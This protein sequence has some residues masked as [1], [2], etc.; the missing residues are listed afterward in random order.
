MLLQQTDFSR[1]KISLSNSVCCDC[2][3][4]Y[5]FVS[6]GRDLAVFVGHGQMQF[7]RERTEEGGSKKQLLRVIPTL[8]PDF[9]DM[10]QML[11]FE[12]E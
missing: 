8:L 1:R 7:N 12:N 2:S 9:K 5:A 4:T 6:E 3:V 10:R 11:A